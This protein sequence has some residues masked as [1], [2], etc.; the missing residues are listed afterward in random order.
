M[1][2]NI[3]GKNLY[4]KILFMDEKIFT[5]EQKFNKQNEKV[6]A[7]TSYEAKAKIPIIQRGYHLSTVMMFWKCRDVGI[8]PFISAHQEYEK[9]PLKSTKEPSSS[10]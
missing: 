3:Y 2:L 4:E 5:R 10:P 1:L 8:L 6:Y 7:L 9:Q